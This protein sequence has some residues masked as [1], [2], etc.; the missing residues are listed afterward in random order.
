MEISKNL[1]R[2]LLQECAILLSNSAFLA[3][4]EMAGGAGD[5]AGK[6]TQDQG[7]TRSLMGQDVRPA[8]SLLWKGRNDACSS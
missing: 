6:K 1:H 2:L 8:L 4:Y 5:A 7:I 3:F